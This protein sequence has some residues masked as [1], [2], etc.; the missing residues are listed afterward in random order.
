MAL[1]TYLLAGTKKPSYQILAMM[2]VTAFLSMWMSNTAAAV[3]ML[4][5]A[6]SVTHLVKQTNPKIPALELLFY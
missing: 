2:L 1:K 3:M 6:L 5:I 4:P